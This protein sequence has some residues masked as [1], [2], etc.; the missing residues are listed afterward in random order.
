MKKSTKIKTRNIVIGILFALIAGVTGILFLF[1]QE[2]L[3]A[4]ASTLPYNN[5][6]LTVRSGISSHVSNVTRWQFAT[7]EFQNNQG[8]FSLINDSAIASVIDSKRGTNLAQQSYEIRQ[9]YR[10]SIEPMLTIITHGQGGQ[11]SDWSNTGSSSSPR[12]LQYRTNS[13]IE[14]LR[15]EHG[16]N[17][18]VVRSYL[19]D[20]DYTVNRQRIAAHQDN[21]INAHNDPNRS[22][23]IVHLFPGRV[24]FRTGLTRPLISLFPLEPNNTSYTNVHNAIENGTNSGRLTTFRNPNRH[25][26]IIFESRDPLQYRNFVYNE[27]NSILTML[28]YDVFRASEQVPLVDMIGHSTGSVWNMMW[29]SRHYHNV[30]YQF[31]LGG[32]FRGSTIGR[33]TRNWWLA[34]PGIEETLLWGLAVSL[35]NNPSAFD[36]S[37][38]RRTNDLIWYWAHAVKQ[39]PHLRVFAMAGNSCRS[40]D[41]LIYDTV[42]VVPGVTEHKNQN[43]V[44]RRC[45]RTFFDCIIALD[46]LAVARYSAWADDYFCNVTTW[47]KFFNHDNSSRNLVAH[48][49]MREVA[50]NR[51]TKDSQAIEHIRSNISLGH[52][53]FDSS[54]GTIT[55]LGTRIIKNG[56]LRIPIYIGA[57]RVTAIGASA[58]ANQIF[59]STITLPPAITTIGNDAFANT[60][61]NLLVRLAA[62]RTHIQD[63]LFEN[64]QVRNVYIP[65]GIT[66]IGSNAFAGNTILSA[67]ILPGSLTY[68]GYR[69]FNNSGLRE[70]TIPSRVDF[71]GD[72]AFAGSGSLTT[73]IMQRRA[74]SAAEVPALGGFAFFGAGLNFGRFE[75]WLPCWNSMY[76]YSRAQFWHATANANQFRTNAQKT[77]PPHVVPSNLVANVGQRLSEVA[78]P[79]GWRWVSS[80]D[81]VDSEGNQFHQAT[82]THSNPDYYVVTRVVR[83]IVFL[84][85]SWQQIYQSEICCWH[86]IHIGDICDSQEV[87]IYISVYDNKSCFAGSAYIVVSVGSWRYEWLISTSSGDVLVIVNF[88][89]VLLNTYIEF[90]SSPFWGGGIRVTVYSRTPIRWQEVYSSRIET[91]HWIY[92][93][94]VRILRLDISVYDNMTCYAGTRRMYLSC[95]TYEMIDTFSALLVIHYCPV[96]LGVF[97]EPRFMNW[98]QGGIRVTVWALR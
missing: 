48:P 88:C 49:D 86:D 90:R 38:Q 67:I 21:Y 24:G 51:L 2:T 36:N 7:H 19:F 10:I 8:R 94:D 14:V 56:D 74:F 1:Q 32:A 34:N 12:V 11:S 98:W 23:Q 65:N 70:V 60:N 30:R 35:M 52:F 61:P 28:S 45:C 87:K 39:N 82:F 26:I 50:H 47:E 9:Q 57:T 81:F 79:Q 80:N 83:V 69:A 58:F 15:R 5:T 41:A 64:T 85:P 89:A 20:L 63:E 76:W 18:Y 53:G 55:S 71:I 3:T 27:I 59:L 46:D 31:S 66:H 17:V 43:S 16:A 91:C 4:S 13:L 72:A 75:V 33:Y 77:T 97:V 42:R 92:I 40:V 22:S 44:R 84:P 25:N 62:G 95:F 78:L 93:D 54:T 29:A 37:D 6:F 68:I 73:V 96:N